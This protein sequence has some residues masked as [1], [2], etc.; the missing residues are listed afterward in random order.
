MIRKCTAYLQDH[1]SAHP[2]EL[3]TY[4]THDGSTHGS[5]RHKPTEEAASPL[6]A[7]R[8]MP[9]GRTAIG[10]GGFLSRNHWSRRHTVVREV[11]RDDVV[12]SAQLTLHAVAKVEERHG[13]RLNIIF[14]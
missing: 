11:G 1:D 13:G 3:H 5:G 7:F 12:P 9:L 2:A 4:D 8:S 6:M 14:S 10:S